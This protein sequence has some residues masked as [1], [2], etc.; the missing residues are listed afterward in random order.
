MYINNSPP[1]IPM[2][3]VGD[4]PQLCGNYALDE[5]EKCDAGLDGTL[6]LDPCCDS[7]CQFR[8][9]AVCR[10]VLMMMTVC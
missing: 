5:E 6:N 10:L 8:F 9:P 7:S 1:P 2:T 4:R 3:E